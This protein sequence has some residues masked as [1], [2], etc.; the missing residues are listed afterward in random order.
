[1]VEKQPGSKKPKRESPMTSRRAYISQAEIPKLALSEAI[2]LA[3]GLYDNFAGKPTAPHQ[4]ALAIDIS[5]TSS[6]WRELCGA[7]IAYGLTTGG[8]RAKTISLEELGKR[9]VAPTKE[10]DD[11]KAKVEAAL[12]PKIAEQFFKQY[13][14]AKFPQDK[15]ARNVLADMGVPSDRLD[16][17]LEILKRNGEFVR[18]VLQTTTGPFVAIDTLLRPAEGEKSSIPKE[19][20]AIEQKGEPID[21]EETIPTTQIPK[22][23]EKLSRVF[24]AHGKN[25]EIVSQLKDFLVF[26]RFTPVVAEEH[27]TTSK[28]VPEKVLEDM[29]SCYAGILHIES[30]DE[31]L[32]KD[33]KIYHKINE[34]V[35]IEIGAA[36]ALYRHNFILLVQKGIH[37]PSNL[38]GLY[39]CYYEGN[40]LD[41]DATMK[42]LKAFNEFK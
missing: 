16:N 2:S 37:L 18:I 27:E 6:K 23:P 38:Q 30:E 36:M 8:H 21:K 31:L 9:I 34:N 12:R 20:K 3:Q 14:R 35:L 5:P 15:I 19:E 33:G 29:R 7:S 22:I 41:V 26:G 25:K 32:D 1:M 39:V 24:I 10:G 17:V 13:N 40:K 28:P 11:L 42:L 4:L